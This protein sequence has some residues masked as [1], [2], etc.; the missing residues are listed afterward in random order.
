MPTR[1]L[2]AL[3]EIDLLRV[4]EMLGIPPTASYQHSSEYKLPD[5]RK[6]SVSPR[7]L[8]SRSGSQG[9]FQVWNGEAYEGHTGGAGS[10]N[11]YMAVMDCDFK[12]AVN[13]LSEVLQGRLPAVPNVREPTRPL[14]AVSAQARLKNHLPEPTQD[15]LPAMLHYLTKVRCLPARLLDPLIRAGTIYPYRHQYITPTT[16]T[17]RHWL[18]AVFLMRDDLTL[19][20][21]G[22]MIRGCYDGQSPRKSTLPL[23]PGEPAAFWIGEPLATASQLVLTESPIECL[24]WMALH[25]QMKRVHVRTYGGNRWRHVQSLFPNLSVPLIAA[26][27]SDKEGMRASQ[28][29]VS[30]C[31]EAGLTCTESLPN[32]KKDWNCALKHSLSSV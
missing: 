1:D 23:H 12:T 13:A 28:H 3:R 20:P 14:R 18:N 24:S 26:F 10:I 5:G 7:P 29:L 17:V 8:N 9:M 31:N 25:P 21:N 6:I 27:N 19:I 30:L 32:H 15:A 2:T 22:C 16:G 11:L 4:M